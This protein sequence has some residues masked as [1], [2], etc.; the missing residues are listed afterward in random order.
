MR[1]LN[2]VPTTRSC[3]YSRLVSSECP[4]FLRAVVSCVSRIVVVFGF[5]HQSDARE[6][7]LRCSCVSP[8][9]LMCTGMGGGGT[10]AEVSAALQSV[11]S[12][13]FTEGSF[14]GQWSGLSSQSLD[15]PS[16]GASRYLISRRSVPGFL[17]G[18]E[19]VRV[20]P[21]APLSQPGNRQL[22]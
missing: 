20:R 18:S 3:L 15:S 14:G 7:V 8:V 22:H 10:N 6:C 16:D 9:G 1:W 17:Y 13:M 12:F 19:I 2:W 4:E 21:G 11:A 5:F